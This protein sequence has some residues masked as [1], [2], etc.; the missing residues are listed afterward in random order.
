MTIRRSKRV[1]LLVVGGVVVAT[2]VIVVGVVHQGSV[3]ADRARVV[4]GQSV[5]ENR[6]EGQAVS[7]LRSIIRS[8]VQS[9]DEPITQAQ[10]TYDST[11]G[12]ASEDARDAL[13]NAIAEAKNA[14]PA[15]LAKVELFS[16]AKNL[17]VARD[18]AMTLISTLKGNLVT[19]VAAPQE[20]ATAFDAAAAVAAQRKA[21]EAA[22]A[23]KPVPGGTSPAGPAT[24][25]VG[26][27]ASAACLGG[28]T[29]YNAAIACI[30]ALDFGITVT[31][32]WGLASGGGE[33]SV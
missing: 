16:D 22:R 1:T 21:A 18:G 25:E 3:D 11:A 30:N 20:Q 19:A 26:T 14:P 23:K 6:W 9:L 7:S 5:A 4:R 8:T 17:G 2:A 12:R 10:A 33:N 28:G 32:E 29:G 13:K 31:V 24:K 15:T 27:A